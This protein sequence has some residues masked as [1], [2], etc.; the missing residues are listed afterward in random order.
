MSV[1]VLKVNDLAT[2]ISGKQLTPLQ[3]KRNLPMSLK[4]MCENKS[5]GRP[6]R[7]WPAYFLGLFV[8]AASVLVRAEDTIPVLTVGS[9]TFSN[10]TVTTKTPRYIVIMHAQGMASIRLKELS[11]DVLKDLGY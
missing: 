8:W 5:L 9:H 11:P 1:A 3:I 4:V 10:V 6:G 7:C 2:L